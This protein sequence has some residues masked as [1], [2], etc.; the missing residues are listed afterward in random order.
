NMLKGDD[1]HIY[2]FPNWY[3]NDSVPT[4]N[5]GWMINTKVHKE[6]G[7]P[8]LDT[9]ADL[10]SYLR[11]VKAKYP[12]IV[13]LE[14]GAG[15]NGDGVMLM[16]QLVDQPWQVWSGLRAV[17][18]F[19]SKEIKPL[20]ADP[21]F[22]DFILYT[23]K[24]FRD[25]LI[26][27]DAFTQTSDQEAEKISNGRIAVLAGADMLNRIKLNTNL[28]AKEPG[29][30]YEAIVPITKDGGDPFGVKLAQYTTLGWNVSV[31]TKTAKDPEKIF[32]FMD[33]ATGEEGQRLFTYGPQGLYWDEVDEQGVPI[34]NEKFNNTPKDQ[35]DKDGLGSLNNWAN[36]PVLDNYSKT[37]EEKYI[38]AAAD[39]ATPAFNRMVEI[40]NK[41]TL[42]VN[43]FEYLTPLPESEEGVIKQKIDDLYKEG[44]AK[45]VFAKSDDEVL[46]ILT[47]LI[48][49]MDKA[50]QEKLFDFSEKQ[51]SKNREKLGK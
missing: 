15:F 8:K 45:M 31:I 38:K 19:E 24:L 29:N 9:L 43:E 18:D 12:N 49:D 14:V 17:V 50:G 40:K 28:M 39:P 51:W 13:P 26:T 25:G 5:S 34:P 37:R 3:T 44:F 21:R 10:E 33:W 27:Q 4:G 36:T 20:V 42:N 16:T 48:S 1:G 46:S 41:Y 7:S 32:A 35:R 47:K 6:L 30:S 22:K 2:G 23:N 11:Q